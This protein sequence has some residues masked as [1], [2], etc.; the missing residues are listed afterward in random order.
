MRVADRGRAGN[1]SPPRSTANSSAMSGGKCGH[2][3]EDL[4]ALDQWVVWRYESRGNDKLT[5]VP[6]NAG[7]SRYKASSTKRSTWSSFEQACDAV[8]QRGFDGVGFVFSKDDDYVG[9]DL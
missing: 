8:V 1:T 5:K 2:I 7:S 3:P 4:Q 9:I 6:Y